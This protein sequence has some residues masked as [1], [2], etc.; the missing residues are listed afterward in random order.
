MQRTDCCGKPFHWN[1]SCAS[2]LGIHARRGEI[3]TQEPVCCT[4]SRKIRG[5]LTLGGQLRDSARQLSRA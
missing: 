1:R 2:T 4:D 3:Y 5:C